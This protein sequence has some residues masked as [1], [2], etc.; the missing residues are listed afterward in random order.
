MVGKRRHKQAVH[1]AAHAIV[2]RKLGIAVTH[3]DLRTDVPHAL[4]AS[5]VDLAKSSDVA[6]QIA[7]YENN[8]K[9]ALAGRAAN[10]REDPDEPVFNLFADRNV[11]VT[12]AA[13]AIYNVIRLK[14]GQPPLQQSMAVN[15]DKATARMMIEV[16]RRLV[17]ETA[18]LVDQHWASIERVAKHLERHGHIDSQVELD[19]LIERARHLS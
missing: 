9:V 14:V 17:Q 18:G 15:I 3:V 13:T 6:E 10:V 16:Y 5:A 4:T 2:A 12:N 11:D 1:E 19:D 7:A 8:A